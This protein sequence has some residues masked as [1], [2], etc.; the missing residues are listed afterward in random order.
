MGIK[1]KTKSQ[2][3]MSFI[4]RRAHFRSP[5]CK[6]TASSLQPAER[7]SS[8]RLWRPKRSK[9]CSF[10][11][12]LLRPIRPIVCPSCSSS[13]NPAPTLLPKIRT[14]SQ[15]RA[16]IRVQVPSRAAKE[17]KRKCSERERQL[18]A[19]LPSFGPKTNLNWPPFCSF[20]Q[21]RSHLRAPISRPPLLVLRAKTASTKGRL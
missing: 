8:G 10:A 1:N 19:P 16:Q 3:L 21:D 20:R 9:G 11:P 15:T 14:Q 4:S 5:Q 12:L 7:P 2:T 13:P 17:P 6:L 18:R